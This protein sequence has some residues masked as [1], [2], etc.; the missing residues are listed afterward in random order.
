MGEA[1]EW[2]VL[3]MVR[4]FKCWLRM[5]ST[6]N[7]RSRGLTRRRWVSG[8]IFDASRSAMA[9]I[10]AWKRQVGLA[11]HGVALRS[12][13]TGLQWVDT[14]S[15]ELCGWSRLGFAP[16][17][18]G[19]PHLPP[20][21]SQMSKTDPAHQKLNETTTSHQNVYALSVISYH[22]AGLGGASG[23]HDTIQAGGTNT[24][25]Y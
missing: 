20:I 9:S 10:S 19:H 6:G 1:E 23:K 25:P 5:T 18:I 22:L 14:T 12:L 16:V 7:R 2:L 24:G 17:P 3:V 13:K 8:F 15:W 21:P 4:R 11:V